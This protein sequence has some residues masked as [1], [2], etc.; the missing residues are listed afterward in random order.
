MERIDASD[1]KARYLAVLDRVHET[2][3][4]VAI[5]KRRRPVAE[6]TCPT[7]E[8]NRYLQT[9]LE[10]TVAILGDVMEPIFPEG[11]WDRLLRRRGDRGRLSGK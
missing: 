5:L 10:G 4:R 2:G 7:G 8:K 6:L 11:H 3:E 9:E 1:F